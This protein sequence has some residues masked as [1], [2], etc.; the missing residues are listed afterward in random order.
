M[1]T[2]QSLLLLKVASFSTFYKVALP[3]FVAVTEV[4]SQEGERKWGALIQWSSAA[5]KQFKLRMLMGS[6]LLQ[7]YS[8]FKLCIC[9]KRKIHGNHVWSLCHTDFNTLL[10]PCVLFTKLSTSKIPLRAVRVTC[11]QNLLMR[12]CVKVI[13]LQLSERRVLS[14]REQLKDFRS[15]LCMSAGHSH[16]SCALL[17]SRSEMRCKDPGIIKTMEPVGSNTAGARKKMPVL[18]LLRGFF[19][20]FSDLP[21]RQTEWRQ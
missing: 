6:F 13:W 2:C 8:F 10:L 19:C 11:V 5:K 12:G 1:A 4:M 18:S 9:I 17:S 21:V 15:S 16:L 14:R 7:T 20:L 3:G